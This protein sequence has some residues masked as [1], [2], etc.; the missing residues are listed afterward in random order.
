M[1]QNFRFIF[2]VAVIGLVA[3][4]VQAKSNK[5]KSAAEVFIALDKKVL[6]D[7]QRKAVRDAREDY[8][9]ALS[10]KEPKFAKHESSMLDGGTEIFKHPF[11]KLTVVRKATTSKKEPGFDFGPILQFSDSQIHSAP[12]ENVKFFTNGELKAFL[13]SRF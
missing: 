2:V 11:Y 6:T 12:I 3:I 7:D 8:D 9:L 13:G 10:G 1:R 4:C 5:I